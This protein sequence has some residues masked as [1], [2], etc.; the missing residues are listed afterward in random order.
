MQKKIHSHVHSK[1]HDKA[2]MNRLS[3]SI[4]HLESIKKMIE[5]GRDCSEILI[6]LAAVRGEINNT[7]KA[8]LKEHLRHCIVHAIEDKDEKKIEELNKAI[9]SFIK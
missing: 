7:G 8:I 2:M 3:Q 4:G 9:N 5:Q 6:Q 1:G